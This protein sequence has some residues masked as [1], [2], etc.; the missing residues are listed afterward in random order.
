MDTRINSSTVNQQVSGHNDST[1]TSQLQQGK[2]RGQ[3][4]TRQPSL[5]SLIADSAEEL[6]FSVSETVEKKLSKRKMSGSKESSLA[7]AVAKAEF[8]LKQIPDL[9]SPERLLQFLEHLKQ[10]GNNNPDQLRQQAKKFFQ[11]P[12][13]AY[14]ALS[15]AMES[16]QE[17]GGDPE[18]VSALNRAMEKEM[19]EHGPVIRAGLNISSTASVFADKGL[20]ETGELRNF[21]REN[22]LEY[23]GLKEL[24][25]SIIERAG[26]GDPEMVLTFFMEALG[27]DLQASG[28][29]LE[30]AE[31]QKILDDLYNV[32]VVV[33][34]SREL[35]GLAS[36]IERLYHIHVRQTP[37]QLAGTLLEL[38]EEKWLSVDKVN[39]ALRDFGITDLEAQIY[40]LR[41]FREIGR[42][43]PIKAFGEGE[44]RARFL[45]ILQ[46][47]LDNCIEMEE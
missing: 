22:V 13:Q 27:A 20:G 7:D 14:A 8:Y 31:L 40:F 10:Q 42:E 18:L 46:D 32:E 47:A 29:S 16:L 15:F 38:K 5:Q 44:D 41:E 1:K 24:Q 34:C 39:S 26:S 43:L 11:D 30:P 25:N 28:S 33:N 23:T 2:L 4:V 21:Y 6:T 36:T 19:D 9:D 45:S 37:V 12:S 17:E 35:K 3:T